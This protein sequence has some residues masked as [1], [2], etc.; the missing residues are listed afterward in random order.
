MTDISRFTSTDDKRTEN[1][2]V[3]HTYRTLSD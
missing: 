2:A 3:R 1:S